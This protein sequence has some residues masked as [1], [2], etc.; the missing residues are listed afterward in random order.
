MNLER[1]KEESANGTPFQMAG[2]PTPTPTWQSGKRGSLNK[3]GHCHTCSN[4]Q[5]KRAC[6]TFRKL[7]PK[8]PVRKKKQAQTL[9]EEM[10][11]VE[12]TT[13]PTALLGPSES[14]PIPHENSAP[15]V[16]EP[17]AETTPVASAPSTPAPQKLQPMMKT[18]RWIK[19]WVPQETILGNGGCQLYRWVIDPNYVPEPIAIKAEPSEGEGYPF[20]VGI[21]PLGTPLTR[22]PS[23]ANL[24]SLEDSKTPP[25]PPSAPPPGSRNLHVCQEEGCGKMFIDASGLRKHAAVHSARQFVCTVDGCGKKF[26]DKSKLKRHALVHTGEKHFFCPYDSCGKAFSLDHNLR[27]HMKTHSSSNYHPCRFPGCDKR[28]VHR[29]KLAAHELQHYQTDDVKPAA[30]KPPKSSTPLTFAK[31]TTAS[32]SARSSPELEPVASTP[33]RSKRPRSGENSGGDFGE[34]TESD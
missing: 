21:S 18:R 1:G 13:D 32:L 34:E 20:G 23:D 29:N 5:L 26:V 4:P 15:K 31:N 10:L 2:T 25:P 22:P 6:V 7:H 8:E 16:E 14:T 28:F 17:V 12:R 30:S 24:A 11:A 33:K 19:S 9:R 3:C 27:S